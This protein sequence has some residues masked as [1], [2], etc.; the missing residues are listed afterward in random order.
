[1]IDNDKNDMIEE[2]SDKDLDQ[3][4]GGGDAAETLGSLAE[5]YADRVSQVASDPVGTFTSDVSAAKDFVK[6]LGENTAAGAANFGSNLQDHLTRGIKSE[7]GR[8][9]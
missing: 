1:M 7:Y 6:T 3:V 5:A 8:S 4:T 9:K 2:I